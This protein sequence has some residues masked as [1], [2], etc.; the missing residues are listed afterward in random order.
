MSKTPA[1]L[2]RDIREF[3]AQK[4]SAPTAP[5]VK[6]SK[7]SAVDPATLTAGAIN[8]E[9][10]RLDEISDRLT[11]RMIAEGRGYERPSDYHRKTDP[12]STEINRLSDRQGDLRN[13][14]E[15]RYGPRPPRRLPSGRFFGPRKKAGD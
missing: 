1:Q 5:K 7:I 3:F 10:D 8:K 6:P 11:D 9:L 15:R 14:I 13:E 12:L 2:D 4:E